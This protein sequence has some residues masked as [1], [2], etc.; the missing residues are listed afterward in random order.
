MPDENYSTGKM[1]NIAVFASGR[2]SNFLA[3]AK[4]VKSGSLKRINLALLVCDNPNAPVILKAK[5]LK[6]KVALVNPDLYP[7]RDD[8]EA[9]VIRHLR[10]S[11]ISLIVLAGFMRMLSASFVAAYKNRIINI[12]PSLLPAFKGSSGIKDAFDYGVKVTGVTVHFVDEKMDHG[13]VILQ[14]E[15]KVEPKDTLSSLEE[16]IHKI[17]HKLYPQAIKLVA[18]GKFKLQGR[19]AV[20]KKG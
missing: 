6:V 18:G 12:H 2:G 4:A 20:F 11:K 7:Q 19:K 3:I 16:R 5:K 17:E 14:K 1:T 8:F 10:D 13:P 15:V 9:R